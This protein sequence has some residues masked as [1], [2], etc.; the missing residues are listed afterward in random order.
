[1]SKIQL[2]VK[3]AALAV[4]LSS[5]L[6]GLIS[7]F[8]LMV[9]CLAQWHA[10]HFVNYNKATDGLKVVHAFL[11]L[12]VAQ[13]TLASGYFQFIQQHEFAVNMN[14]FTNLTEVKA[15]IPDGTLCAGQILRKKA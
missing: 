4:A 9:I 13:L 3:S 10:K 11:M 2:K 14:D 6:F 8:L 7:Q 1:M 12:H 5:V 15:N